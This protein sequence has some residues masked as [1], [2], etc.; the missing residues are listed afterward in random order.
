MRVEEENETEI[1]EES[2]K[3]SWSSSIQKIKETYSRG[4]WE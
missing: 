1:S 3:K 2:R 4:K